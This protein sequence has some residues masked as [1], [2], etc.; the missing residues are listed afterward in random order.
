MAGIEIL[1]VDSLSAFLTFC[2]LPRLVY[3]GAKGFAPSL[4]VE[5]WTI[6]GHKLNPHFK[7]VEA[8]EFLARRDGRWVGRIAAQIYKPD[9]QPIDA[10]RWQFGSLDAI[11]DIEV[12]RGAHAGGGRLA[13]GRGAERVNGPFS[14]SINAEMRLAGRWLRRDA[15][16]VHALASALS[17]APYRGA[18]L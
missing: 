12:V 3:K 17:V 15:D 11:D 8:R 1:P 10:S 2:K 7:L 14:P 5:R 9:I 6:Y 13:R 4:D 16:G 18:R